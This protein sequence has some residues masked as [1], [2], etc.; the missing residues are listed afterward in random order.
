VGKTADALTIENDGAKDL[1]AFIAA[2]F[3]AVDLALKPGSAV[4]VAHPAG[5][6]QQVFVNAFVEHFSL[7][8]QLVWVK[9]TFALG[10]SDYHYR[11]E[12]ILFGYTNGGEG[13][14]GRGGDN[15]HGDNSQDSVFEVDKPSRNGE[16]PTMKPLELIEAMLINST[17]SASILF[18]PFLGSGS[19]LIAAEKMEGTR[20][21]YGFELSPD[22][23]EVICR[24]WEQ[25]TGGVAELA[26]HL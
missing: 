12:P 26:G 4:Y 5:A 18:E 2:A 16:H 20:T 17:H 6:L 13:R 22:Y 1:P 3:K 15:W 24:R 19:T 21:V 7:R 11:H 14:R 23:I 25:F 9:N 10:R 8:Q